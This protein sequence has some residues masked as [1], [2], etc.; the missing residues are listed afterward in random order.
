MGN[1]CP[2]DDKL[3]LSGRNPGELRRA[4][5]LRVL[6]VIVSRLLYENLC[7]VFILRQQ[8]KEVRGAIIPDF[9]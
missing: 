6:N 1:P 3:H 4:P 9:M 2:S 8:I 5:E 7:F